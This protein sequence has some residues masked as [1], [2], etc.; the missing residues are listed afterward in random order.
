MWAMMKA[1]PW[2]FAIG[3]VILLAAI[4]GVIVGV[5]TKGRWEDRGLMVK[6]GHPLSWAKDGIPLPVWYAADIAKGWLDSWVRGA[7]VL[8]QAAGRPLFLNPVEAPDGLDLAKP[9][10]GAVVLKDDNGVDPDHGSTELRWDKRD[11]ALLSAVVVLP[12]AHEDNAK[13]DAV[14]LHEAAHALGLDHDEGKDSIMYPSIQDRPQ[15][16]SG[17]DKELL[18]RVY[19]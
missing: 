10:T 18:R 17:A 7:D 2:T 16:L 1:N 5:L 4:V 6:D 13:R 14:A 9:V 11:G 8:N 12:E 15:E 19:G 3:G